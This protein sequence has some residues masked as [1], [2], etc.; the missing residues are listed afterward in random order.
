[1]QNAPGV[2]FIVKEMVKHLA[3]LVFVNA[4]FIF[5]VRKSTKTGAEVQYQVNWTA[6]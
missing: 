5:V 3:N 6:D 4:L 2:T 1:M